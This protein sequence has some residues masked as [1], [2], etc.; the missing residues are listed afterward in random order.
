MT[1]YSQAACTATTFTAQLPFAPPEDTVTVNVPGALYD[2]KKF[3]PFP[4]LGDPFGADQLYV[5]FPPDAAKAAFVP[6]FTEPLVPLVRVH[7][8]AATGA[9]NCG[10]VT[11]WPATL[12]VPVRNPSV[13]WRRSNV[14]LSL[15]TPLF[16]IHDAFDTGFHAHP[17]GAVTVTVPAPPA[18]GKA[19]KLVGCTWNVHVGGGTDAAS[20]VIC[21]D[22]PHTLTAPERG[23]VPALSMRKDNVVPLPES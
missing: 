7:D 15:K 5:P 20:W 8:G 16:R 11:V 4:E 12:I 22:C 3:P 23:V 1:P 14:N 21:R 2:E 9:A 13:F 17:L 6:T 18:A 10:T 19:G